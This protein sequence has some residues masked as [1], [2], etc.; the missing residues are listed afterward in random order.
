MYRFPADLKLDALIGCD[1]NL[2]GLGRYDVQLN[3]GGS[4]I[5][6]GIQGNISL[7]KDGSTIAVWN[8][9][10]NWS[11]LAFQ[12]LLNA[13]VKGYSVPNDKLL[14]LRFTNGLALQIHDDSDQF[15]A[16]QIYFEDQT[17][18]VVVI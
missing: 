17:H 1:L 3:F 4:G 12:E 15:E 7:L 9:K 6:F 11:S 8:E 14:E 16:M 18:S 13:T 10:E 2:L 5:K